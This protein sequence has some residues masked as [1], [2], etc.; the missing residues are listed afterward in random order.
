[1]F[2]WAHIAIG[3]LTYTVWTK[4][5]DARVP[6]GAA[7]IALAVGTQFPDLLDKPLG[8]WLGIY[9]G[10]GIGHS[11]L[12]TAVLCV[13]LVVVARRYDREDLAGAFAIGV[14]T[15]L[16]ADAA[17]PLATGSLR[18]AG[19]LLWPFVSP[20]TYP[21]DSLLDHLEVWLVQLRL[22]SQSS[23]LGLLETR[24]GLQFALFALLVFVWALDGF[25][26][27]R[28]ALRLFVRSVGRSA[29]T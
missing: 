24:F 22:L 3:Y 11:I 26:G 5:W 21:K 23:P 17:G 25:P 6:G 29:S 15:H 9:D 14:G 4:V 27:L 10:R 8:W 2:P 12:A 20:P 13:A 18:E 28:T 16:V 1:M 19:F 7:T